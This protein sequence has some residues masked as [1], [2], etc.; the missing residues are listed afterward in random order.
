MELRQQLKRD[1]D[2]LPESV[3]I[4]V[5]NLISLNAPAKNK[6]KRTIEEFCGCMK[7]Q[8]VMA[9]DFNAPI[10]DFKEYME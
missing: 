6:P 4:M 10:D 3:L 7:G 5:S 8:F 9:D 1:I 2:T